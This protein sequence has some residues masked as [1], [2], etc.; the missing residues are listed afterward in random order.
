MALAPA[1][2][3]WIERDKVD[4]YNRRATS[5]FFKLAN[6]VYSESHSIKWASDQKEAEFFETVFYLGIG[7]GL[8]S[9]RTLKRT[10]ARIFHFGEPVIARVKETGGGEIDI[11]H[12]EWALF[13][14]GRIVSK[15]VMGMYQGQIIV[16]DAKRRSY[17]HNI[18][19]N[20]LSFEIRPAFGGRGYGLAH[21]PEQSHVW[22]FLLVISADDALAMQ[23]RISV[24]MTKSKDPVSYEPT[25]DIRNTGKA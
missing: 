10:Q 7:N 19:Q 13:E 24:D 3:Y 4:V 16:D 21:R 11:R 8:E 14:I 18:P 9:G 22:S 23:V 15:E 2:L 5:Q 12:G 1:R 17:E 6:T 25:E 20:F